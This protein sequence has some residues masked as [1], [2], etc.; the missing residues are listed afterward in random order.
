MQSFV[1]LTDLSQRYF[2][3]QIEQFR[4]FFVPVF[5]F[6]EICSRFVV[7]FGMYF[8]FRMVPD[9]YFGQYFHSSAVE[10]FFV[11]PFLKCHDKFPELR[12]PV[13]QMIYSYRFISQFRIYFVQTSAEYGSI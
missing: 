3:K 13:A 10:F 4:S 8:R 6:L 12:S 11:A 1:Y 2:L 5:Y 7:H 9:V